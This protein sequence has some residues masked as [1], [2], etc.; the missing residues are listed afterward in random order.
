MK[1]LKITEEIA[2]EVIKV[3][4]KKFAN[5]PEDA[6][7]NRNAPFHEAFLNA[8]SDKLKGKVTD[9]PYF[10]SLSSWLHGLN[11]T[12]GQTF[13]ENVSHILSG[14]DK[15]EFTS[16]K[17]TLLRVSQEQKYAIADIIT[18][19]KNGDCKPH[20]N[21]ENKLIF[22][23]NTNANLDANSFTAD[24]FI[25]EESK[26]IAI[27]L[28]TVKPNAGE[29]R[30]E[31]QK[32]LE[33][34]AALFNRFNDKEIEYYMG[35]PF[36]PTSSTSTGS[37]KTRFL[38]SIIDGDKYLA[39]NEVLLANELWNFLSGFK[40]TMEL[41]LEI[42]NKIATKD[43]KQKFEYLNNNAN[44][45]NDNYKTRLN[46]WF[47]FSEIELLNNDPEICKNLSKDNRAI[48]IY[49]QPIF[50]EERYGEEK[51]K[52]DYNLYRYNYLKNLIK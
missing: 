34:K 52:I 40:N 2:I 5:F 37:D 28:K 19:L 30:G 8:F 16:K 11:T 9:I 35:F 25:E 36:D 4:R 24:V 23:E 42:I 46:D 20:L 22:L 27:E 47:L 12:L 14:G 3:L 7:N 18:D 33:A 26:I 44:R 49:T 10:I 21:R 43:F 41:L 32:I 15:K 39:P 48:K 13:F 50:K 1:E 29:M 17:G 31:K 6:S 51:H 45:R 38:S